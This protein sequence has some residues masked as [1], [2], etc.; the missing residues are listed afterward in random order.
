MLRIRSQCDQ[1]SSCFKACY[2][3]TEKA[4]SLEQAE[5]T[6]QRRTGFIFSFDHDSL[7]PLNK[8]ADPLLCR[9]TQPIPQIFWD[10]IRPSQELH[11]SLPKQQCNPPAN[12]P[13]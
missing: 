12:A 5:F 7:Y 3:G 9:S 1:S 13:C 2:S 4:A 10:L 8:T 11:P 6:L